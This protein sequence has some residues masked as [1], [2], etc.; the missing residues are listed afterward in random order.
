[1]AAAEVL[2]AGAGDGV[3]AGAGAVVVVV[4]AAVVV[5]VA[6]FVAAGAAGVVVVAAAFAVAV[7]LTVEPPGGVA[8]GAGVGFAVCPRAGCASEIAAI[9]AKDKATIVRFIFPRSLPRGLGLI[10]PHR[11]FP[12]K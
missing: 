5:A 7:V 9:A 8:T 10:Q 3:V 12:P 4:G 6:E 11:L 2:V 1:V